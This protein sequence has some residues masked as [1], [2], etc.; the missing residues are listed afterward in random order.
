MKAIKKFLRD[1]WF[2]CCIV[3][4]IAFI[5]AETALFVNECIKELCRIKH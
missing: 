4:A 1:N 3:F 5:A 2:E